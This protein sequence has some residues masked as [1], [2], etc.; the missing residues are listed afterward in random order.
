MPET[1]Q[2]RLLICR[3]CKTIE[4]LPDYSGD[5]EHDYLLD[6]LVKQHRTNEVEHIGMLARVAS[7]DWN[8]PAAQAEISKRLVKDFGGETGLGSDFYN[9]RDTLREDAMSCWGQHLR[10]PDC[11]DYKSDAK[12]LT[13]GTAQARKEA[14]MPAFRTKDDR[15]LCEF[16]PV[17]SMVETKRYNDE[18]KRR[19]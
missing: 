16:C 9:T 19:R 10:T 2:V 8:N 15:Y 4:P 11:N 6:Y 14:G 5:V 3:D 13:P 7:S 1:E 12:R 17:H 18:M